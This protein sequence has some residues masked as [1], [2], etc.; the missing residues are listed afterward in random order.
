MNYRPL[1]RTGIKVSLLGYGGWAIGKKGWPGVDEKEAVKTLEAAVACGINF[2]DTAPIYGFG[3]SEEVLGEVLSGMRQHLFLATKCGL[4]WNDR[5]YV[6]HNL[7]ADSIRW[8][9]DQSLKR[10]KTDYIDL[11]QLHWPDK[12]TPL[13]ETLETFAKLQSQGCIRHIGLCNFK[14]EHIEKALRHTA[15]AS[16]QEQYNML[17]RNA[18]ADHLPL[19][20]DHNLGFICYSP[21]AQG[22]LAGKFTRDYKPGS[23]DVRRLN[24][25]FRNRDAFAKAIALVEKTPSCAAAQALCFLARQEAVSTMLVSMTQRRHLSANCRALNRF[26][27]QQRT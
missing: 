19:C 8:E 4:R 17:Q 13:E 3:R 11:Y 27:H 14:A 10:L 25:L 7:T 24:P 6:Q 22:L 21:L 5:G 1:G 16:V 15:I 9:L 20:R 26:A 18:E 2:F 12:N 23:R